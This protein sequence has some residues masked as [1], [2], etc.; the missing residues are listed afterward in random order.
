MRSPVGE[1]LSTG[2]Q[3]RELRR[4]TLSDNGDAR[5]FYVKRLGAE[6]ARLHL[7]SLFFARR[8]RSGPLREQLLLQELHAAGFAVMESVAWGE[9][10]FYGLPREGFL[11]VREVPGTSV[12]VLY[13]ELNSRSRQDLMRDMG[14]LV[15]RLHAH[16]FFQPVRLKDLIKSDRNG[17]GFVL[18]DRETSK[19]WPAR[20]SQRQCLVSLGRSCRRVL[21]DGHR[22]GGNIVRAFLEGYLAG[23]NGRLN[24]APDQLAERIS[25]EIGY[26]APSRSNERYA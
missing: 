2:K 23:C 4:L 10:R 7:R 9:A 13:G 16:G 15:G 12:D 8:P 6:P 18:I 17:A 21:R 22:F 24:L 25:R 3:G 20:F 19:P 1:S 5:R 14:N 11:V 26:P